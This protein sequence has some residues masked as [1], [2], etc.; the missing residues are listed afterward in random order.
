[1]INERYEGRPRKCV[2]CKKLYNEQL[3]A[4]LIHFDRGDNS[5][6][7]STCRQGFFWRP[8]IVSAEKKVCSETIDTFYRFGL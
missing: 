2:M 5:W 8:T 1:M 7:A 3:I 4:D 6:S